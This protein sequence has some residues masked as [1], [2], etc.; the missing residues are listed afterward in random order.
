MSNCQQRIEAY[1]KIEEYRRR[2][3]LVY[4]TNTRLNAS[5]N[6]AGDAVR[7]FQDR[8]HE[9]GRGK[10]LD[11]MI[12]SNG[13]DPLVA[14]RIMSIL[15]AAFAEVDILVPC[16][17]FSAAT[18]MALGA[19][20]IVMHPYSCLGPTDP[21]IFQNTGTVPMQFGYEDVLAFI[22]FLKETVGIQGEQQLTAAVNRLLDEASPIAL[23]VAQR[24]SDL[25]TDIGQRM[26]LMHMK[27]ADD[28]KR[29]SE[30]VDRLNKTFHS[31][32]DAVSREVA[33]STGLQVADDDE[34]LEHLMWGA[35]L[36]L[37]NHMDLRT[38]YEPIAIFTGHSD[39]A[40]ALAPPPSV[41][42]PGNLSA[43]MRQEAMHNALQ[44]LSTIPSLEVD[45]TLLGVVIE[46]AQGGAEWLSKQRISA[47]RIG[48]EIMV[49]VNGS[50]TEWRPVDLC[51]P[52]EENGSATV[53][54]VDL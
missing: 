43:P 1:R 49:T 50:G 2:P 36:K 21:Q 29:V 3:L 6:I 19:N 4:F 40:Q 42:I 18:V 33:R 12:H 46:G 20:N 16:Q 51:D 35:F 10:A 7:E 23:G 22:R 27:G 45:Y 41:V 53:A 25:A 11:L 37:E 8:V 47:R 14:C 44:Q 34:E 24:S 38:P 54:E 28:A 15:R 5:A 32:S 26:M 13:G 30:V 17:A 31:H 39:S 52:H 48:D 9:L